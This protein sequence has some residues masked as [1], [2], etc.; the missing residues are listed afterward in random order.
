MKRS[1][2]FIGVALAACALGVGLITA[3]RFSAESEEETPPQQA[4]TAE[5]LRYQ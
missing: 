1:R 5:A 4:I 3:S 2:V